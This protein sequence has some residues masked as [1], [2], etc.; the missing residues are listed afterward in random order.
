MARVVFASEAALCE[1]F[2]QWAIPQGWRVYPETAGWDLLLVGPEGHQL[3]VQAKLRLNAKALAQATP[4]RPSFS[5]WGRDRGPDF[6][7]ILVPE[8][9]D[10]SEI[11][12]MIG[13]AVITPVADSRG[14]LTGFDYTTGVYD[15]LL[16]PARGL[17]EWVLTDWNPAEREV[18]PDYIPDVAA[19]V[20]SPRTLS[21]WKVAA[22]RVLAH[23][24]VRGEISRKEIEAFG[25]NSRRWCASDAWLS[26]GS[27]RGRWKRGSCPDFDAQHPTVYSQVLREVRAALDE[28]R[29]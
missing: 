13:I 8:I 2:V 17:A 16:K 26:P 28:A 21:P 7:A 14:V 18:L 3:G 20:S 6:R 10:L 23:L 24:E 5:T 9:S 11:A 19:G 25:I 27:A 1:A 15:D 22:L 29:G 12:T 4:S